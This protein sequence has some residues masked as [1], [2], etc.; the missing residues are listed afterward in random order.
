[1][2]V[3][4][5]PDDEERLRSLA[6]EELAAKIRRA[7]RIWIRSLSRQAPVVVAIEDVH[8][9]DPSSRELLD[10]L[11]ELADVA[12]ILLI[13]TFR[14]D[15]ASEGWRL[16]MRVLTDYSHRTVELP[17][18]PLDDA[19]ARELLAGRARS[20]SL[21]PAEIEQIIAGAEGNPLYLEE[22]LNAFTDQNEFIGGRTWAPTMTTQKRVLTPALESLLLARI[23]RLPEQARRF[24]QIAA[25]IGRSF[26]R[27]V[28][29]HVS[30]SDD[31]DRDLALLLR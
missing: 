22:L 30:A 13:A 10:D 8:W 27:R 24:A 11:L 23:D 28:L 19:S 9:S 20:S 6:P 29:D 18:V 25:L 16:R 21:R 7:Y 31:V 5:D 14:M 2:S 4:L 3:K 26:P 12:P 1:M 17:L 15:T